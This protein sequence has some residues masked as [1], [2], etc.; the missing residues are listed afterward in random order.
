MLAP[1][2]ALQ[3]EIKQAVR[4]VVEEERQILVEE[5]KR[6]LASQSRHDPDEQLDVIQAAELLNKSVPAMRKLALRG[7]VPCRRLGRQLRFR[8]GDLV[9]LTGAAK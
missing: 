5:F 4:E 9:A 8:R 3:A 6:A 2:T 7:R 1:M